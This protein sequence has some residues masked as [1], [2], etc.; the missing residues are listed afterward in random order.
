MTT[1]IVILEVRLARDCSVPL[2]LSA[3]VVL[4]NWQ[5]RWGVPRGT[6]GN[7]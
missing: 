5:Q 4:N 7:V 6:F 3:A 1:V 2:D